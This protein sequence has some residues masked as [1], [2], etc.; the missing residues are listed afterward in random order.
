MEVDKK[1]SMSLDD[2]I[3]TGGGGRSH[4]HGA[5]RGRG[6]QRH[7]GG[8]SR[9]GFR[10]GPR[11][12]NMQVEKH[13]SLT[14]LQVALSSA[15]CYS[16]TSGDTVLKMNDTELLLVKN[17]GEI[18]ISSGGKHDE[19]TF[20]LLNEA[21]KP[22]SMKV[23]HDGDVTGRWNVSDG[24]TFVETLHDGMTVREPGPRGALGRGKPSILLQFLQ[25]KIKSAQQ[26]TPSSS[27][28]NNGSFDQAM[29]MSDMHSAPLGVRQYRSKPYVSNGG[30]RPRGRGGFRGSRRTSSL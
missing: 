18:W 25:Q 14:P 10:R 9:G 2:I 22:L 8:Q 16:N 26:P 6:N 29:D 4:P 15:L 7:R 11:H 23:T 30:Y 12:S 17:T 19:E 27:N 21:L 20:V 1:L 13:V 28:Y 5:R 24:K 3:E